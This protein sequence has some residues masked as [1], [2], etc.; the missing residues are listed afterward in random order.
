MLYRYLG[1]RCDS[2]GTLRLLHH[3]VHHPVQN[4]S[5]AQ[6]VRRARRRD[7]QSKA[8]R[9]GCNGS[10]ANAASASPGHAKTS[11]PWRWG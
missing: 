2:R 10:R 8:G 9:G 1:C 11:K 6:K 3:T 4:Q 7:S 5:Q